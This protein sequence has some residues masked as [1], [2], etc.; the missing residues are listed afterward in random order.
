[1]RLIVG[2]LFITDAEHGV[3]NSVRYEY[4]TRYYWRKAYQFGRKINYFTGKFIIFTV[5]QFFV[6]KNFNVDFFLYSEEDQSWCTG[7]CVRLQILWILGARFSIEEI[8]YFYI[9]NSSQERV[10]GKCFASLRWAPPLSTQF[11]QN[12]VESGKRKCL[13]LIRRFEY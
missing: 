7:T 11:L 10:R 6:I 4:K 3:R 1:M 13:N 12:L 8:K 5:L 2:P 9:F